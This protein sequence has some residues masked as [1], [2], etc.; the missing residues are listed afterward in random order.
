MKAALIVVVFLAGCSA[1]SFNKITTPDG[2]QTVRVQVQ[3]GAVLTA[4]EQTG[5]LCMD[6]ASAGICERP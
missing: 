2:I 6:A 3:N 5:E 1:A 4:N